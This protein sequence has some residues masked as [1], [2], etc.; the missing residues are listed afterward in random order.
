MKLT[1][2]RPLERGV[3]ALF[4]CLASLVFG[5][6]R[7]RTASRARLAPSKDFLPALRFATCL[8][9]HSAEKVAACV[10]ISSKAVGCLVDCAH[11]HPNVVR[12]FWERLKKLLRRMNTEDRIE[13]PPKSHTGAELRPA[14]SSFQIG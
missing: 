10:V 12:A 6:W 9:Q 14:L 11:L 3:Q 2:V 4:A 13:Q 7:Q 5:L 1:P 8:H